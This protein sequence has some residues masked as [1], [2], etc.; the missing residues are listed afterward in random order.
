MRHYVHN[1]NSCFDLKALSAFAVSKY[2]K[3]IKRTQNQAPGNGSNMIKNINA[4]MTNTRLIAIP[5]I[6]QIK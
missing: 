6:V 4:N 3:E 1:L 2:K 5:M